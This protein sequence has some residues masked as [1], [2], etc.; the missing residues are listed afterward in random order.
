MMADWTSAIGRAR[1]H[2]PFL[3]LALERRPELAE[4]LAAGQGEAALSLARASGEGSDD[5]ALALRRERLALALV[6]AVGD[7]AGA[8]GLAQVMQALSDFA[9]R[10][11]DTA[12]LAAV[13][14]R[15]EGADTAGFIGL[16]LGK[17]G[18]HELNYS[19]DIDPILLYHPDLIARRERDEPGEAAQRY[20]RQLVEM[21]SQP[22]GEGYVLRVDLRLRPASE[23]S[24]LAIPVGGAIS[25]YE[26]SAL[27]WERAAFIRARAAAGD[28]AAGAAFL[29]DIRP[30]V[31]RKSLDFTAIEEIRRLTARIR[32]SYRGPQVPGPGFDVKKGRGGI[33]EIEFYAQTHQLIF[34]GRNPALRVRGTRAAL[35]ALAGAGVIAADDAR[36]L[37]ASYDRLRIIEHRLQMV[38]DRQTHQLP[39]GAEAIDGVARLDGLADGAALVGELTDICGAVAARYDD[40]L[41][42]DAAPPV[43]ITVPDAFR[44]RFDARDRHWRESYRALRSAEARKAFAAMRVDLLQALGDAPDPDRALARWETLLERL[45]T[46]INLFRLF[47]ERPGLLQRVL[48]ILTLAQPLADALARRPELLDRLFDASGGD[49]PCD[50]VELVARMAVAESSDYEAA[51]GRLR[52]VVGEERFALG[53]QLIECRHD[54]LA[55]AEGLSRLAEAAVATG[56]ALAT[57]DFRRNHGDIADSELVVLGLGRLGGGALTHASDLDV[58][59]LFTGEIGVESDGPRPLSSTLYYNRLATRVTAA[60]SVPTAEGALYEIDTRL[61]PQGQ[62]G[63]LAVSFTAFEKYQ[64]ED[65]WTWEHMALA[66]ARPLTGSP[67]ARAALEAIIADVLGTPRDPETLRAD[68][69]KMRGDMLA[70]KP[71]VGPLDVK[72]LRGGLVDSEFLVHYLQLRDG[73]GLDPALERAIAAQEEAGL[74]PPG[75]GARHL[76]LTRFL[77]AGRLFAPDGSDP[78]PAARPVLARVCGH[79]DYDALLQSLVEARQGIAEAWRRHFDERLEIDR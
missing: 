54:P 10:A 59:Y 74:L 26:S 44:E 25:H 35:D 19:S 34:G 52:Q 18:A 57:R 67:P 9:D 13:R 22:T 31:W 3:R 64:R 48:A 49:L 38:D 72:L 33:R 17:Q 27:A 28:L 7:L 42:E 40:L 61:R 68:V 70:A 55:V 71:P 51:L 53:V 47:E 2:S 15:V 66:R 43:Q 39:A 8:F 63:P 30:F 5:A 23:V 41:G 79:A 78:P 50:V 36:I 21:L 76:A 24:P 46:A 16:A 37:G 29:D 1:A 65:A 62:Q 20:A 56:A 4:L 14:R 32:Q 75:H 77:V 11:L 12:M 73:V 45:P 60:L 69:L 6:L 58:V